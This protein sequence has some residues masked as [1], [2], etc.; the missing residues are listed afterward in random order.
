MLRGLPCKRQAAATWLEGRGGGGGSRRIAISTVAQHDWTASSLD[1]SQPVR[2]G[3]SLK[4]SAHSEKVT[5]FKECRGS[6]GR[7]EGP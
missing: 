6:A 4:N 2:L 3:L 1:S 7:R 5:P